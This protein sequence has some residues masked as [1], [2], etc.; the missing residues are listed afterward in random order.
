MKPKVKVILY[1]RHE[2]AGLL[3]DEFSLAT[4]A[5]GDCPRLERVLHAVEYIFCSDRLSAAWAA[6]NRAMGTR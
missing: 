2:A 4:L 3:G 6:A 5:G 1:G